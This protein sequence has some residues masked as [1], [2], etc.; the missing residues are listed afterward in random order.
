MNQFAGMLPRSLVDYRQLPI[1]GVG[2]IEIRDKFPFMETLLE[3]RV[4]VL[5][6]NRFNGTLLLPSNTNALFPKL[7]VFDIANNSFTDS[8]LDRFLYFFYSHVRCHAK[9][10]E[11]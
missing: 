10:N 4:L 8:L 3:L 9:Y 7:Q 6:S 5:R 1:L 11:Q 2:N